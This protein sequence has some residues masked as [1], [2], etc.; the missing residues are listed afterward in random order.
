MKMKR[1]RTRD[2][3]VLLMQ[4]ARKDPQ[5]FHELVFNPKRAVSKIT[6]LDRASK[7]KLLKIRPQAI[8]GALMGQR[9]ACTDTCISGTCSQTCAGQTC[10]ETCYGSCRFTIVTDQLKIDPRRLVSIRM[11]PEVRRIR[12]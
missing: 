7:A 9:A 11:R 4:R 3:L 6:F 1:A 5:F 12:G 2:P 10:S 8:V